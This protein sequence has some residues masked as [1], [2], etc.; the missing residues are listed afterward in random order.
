MENKYCVQGCAW[1][2][3]KKKALTKAK[4]KEDLESLFYVR[5]VGVT[6]ATLC[7]TGASSV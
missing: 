1:I 3:K 6:R 7:H 5:R 2:K 4:A